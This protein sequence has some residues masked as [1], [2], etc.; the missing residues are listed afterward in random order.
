MITLELDDMIIHITCHWCRNRGSTLLGKDS[1]SCLLCQDEDMIDMRRKLSQKVIYYKIDRALSLSH[2][3]HS[4][5]D[6]DDMI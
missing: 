3:H 4:K 6:E 5:C 1:R 2:S